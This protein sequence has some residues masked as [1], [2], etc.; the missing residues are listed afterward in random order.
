MYAVVYS[1]LMYAND[2]SE[3]SLV[4]YSHLFVIYTDEYK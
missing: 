3:K 2:V 1:I 4:T